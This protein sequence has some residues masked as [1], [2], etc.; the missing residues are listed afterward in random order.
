MRIS[1]N[2]MLWFLALAVI[3]LV[4]VVRY[5]SF[6]TQDKCLDSGGAWNDGRCSY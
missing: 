5:S 4:V 2:R 6:I 3:V 1:G